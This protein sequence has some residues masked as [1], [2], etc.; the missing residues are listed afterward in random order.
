MYSVPLRLVHAC[1]QVTEQVWHPM[2][3]SRFI[4]IAIC[5]ISLIGRSAPGA[6]VL[7]LLAAAA[8]HRDLVPLAAGRAEVVEGEAELGVAADQVARLDQ[9]PGERVVD[10]TALA[11][12]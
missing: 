4:T 9:Q 10:A 7:H 5:A 11:A 3:L 8:D 6:S 2:H 12:G 1:L